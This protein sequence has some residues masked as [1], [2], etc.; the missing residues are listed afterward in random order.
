MTSLLTIKLALK[1]ANLR[2][3]ESMR[4]IARA[5]Q[6]R[7]LAEFEKVLRDYKEGNVYYLTL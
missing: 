3:V 4:A 1:Y 5:H 7:N 2:E 6:G